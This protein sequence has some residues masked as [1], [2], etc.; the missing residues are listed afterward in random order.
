MRTIFK[1]AAAGLAAMCLTLLAL[2][3]PTEAGRERGTYPL[4]RFHKKRMPDG[5]L[6]LWG[7]CCFPMLQQAQIIA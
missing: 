6:R 1:R 2:S 5:I 4:Q 3:I 7:V